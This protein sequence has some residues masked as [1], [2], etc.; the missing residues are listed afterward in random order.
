MK[1]WRFSLFH[2]ILRI[3]SGFNEIDI[4][5][6]LFSHKNKLNNLRN[7]VYF[8]NSFYDE[9]LLEEINQ[10]FEKKYTPKKKYSLKYADVLNRIGE[11]KRCQRVKDCATYWEYG[12]YSDKSIKFHGANFCKDILCPVCA[13]RKSLKLFKEVYS[14]VNSLISTGKYSFLFVTLTVKDVSAEDLDKTCDLLRDS[15]VKLLDRKSYKQKRI[16]TSRN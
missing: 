12:V 6:I 2:L 16:F 15:Y 8:L 5:Y 13:K 11:D 1:K 4:K 3:F 14:A 10:D 7:G 9:K